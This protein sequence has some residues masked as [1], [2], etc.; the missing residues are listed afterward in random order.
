MPEPISPISLRL[1]QT[2]QN[3]LFAN[4]S[5]RPS[6]ISLLKTVNSST[7]LPAPAL[8]VSVVSTDDLVFL[9][10]LCLGPS[11]VVAEFKGEFS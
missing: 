8:Q 4:S 1:F 10:L 5:Y 11:Q 6:P 2:A 9:Y 7:K 3:A